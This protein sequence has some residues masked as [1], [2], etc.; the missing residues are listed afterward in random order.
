[1]TGRKHAITLLDD[2]ATTMSERAKERDQQE[3][4]S[5]AKI[6]TM[7]NTLHGTNLTESQGWN[8]MVLLK[9][10]RANIGDNFRPDD[11]IDQLAYMA[12]EGESRS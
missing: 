1:M 10:V 11:Y 7:F 6:V 9:M 12:L 8:F 4:R 3:E 2:A 5:M